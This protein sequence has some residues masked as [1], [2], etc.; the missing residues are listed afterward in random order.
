ML[1][2]DSQR[3]HFTRM[4]GQKPGHRFKHGR[5]RLSGRNHSQRNGGLI[6]YA[7]TVP[8]YFAPNLLRHQ[9]ILEVRQQIQASK[10]FKMNE[11][12]GVTYHHGR[13]VVSLGHAA[14]NQYPP[15]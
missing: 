7:G 8:L 14:P 3:F 11:R 12:P 10:L 2:R 4:Q 6:E 15:L 9:N 1:Q 13:T 5:Q